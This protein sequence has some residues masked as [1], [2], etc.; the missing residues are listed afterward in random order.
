MT[1]LKQIPDSAS[2]ADCSSGLSKSSSP[3][4]EASETKERMKKKSKK[5]NDSKSK[6]KDSEERCPKRKHKKHSK[7]KCHHRHHHR[8]K[9]HHKH[10]RKHRRSEKHSEKGKET[11]GG[12]GSASLSSKKSADAP[13]KSNLM[14]R[15]RTKSDE[16]QP[17][18]SANCPIVPLPLP[19]RELADSLDSSSLSTNDQSSDEMASEDSV[20]LSSQ[21]DISKVRMLMPFATCCKGGG[22]ETKSAY[23]F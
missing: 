10:H 9:H 14:V 20:D 19:Q 22:S 7:D 2:N 18:V 15:I 16:Q 1:E 21:L 17:L 4:N 12:C 11:T 3:P 13:T 5:R 23:S 6:R 8:H